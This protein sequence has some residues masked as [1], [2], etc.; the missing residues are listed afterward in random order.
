[1]KKDIQLEDITAVV[2][3]REQLP[4]VLDPM[5]V[6]AGTLQH[7]DYSVKGLETQL[8]IERKTLDDFVACCGRER[9][10]FQRELNAL[11]G[12]T[13]SA[14]IIESDW[15]TIES[16][17]WRSRITPA[18]VMGSITSWISQGHCI[19]LG[20]DRVMSQR[21]CRSI[22]FHTAR[23]FWRQLHEFRGFQKT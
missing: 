13:V 16:G 23:R 10:R 20:G 5:Q 9:E 12:Y 14:I 6:Q 2:D 3:T 22:L 18:S 7:G 8:T 19:I 11:R 17:G 1:M 15:Q 21:I 4:F